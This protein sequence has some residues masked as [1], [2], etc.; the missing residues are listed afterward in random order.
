MGD[1]HKF[2]S[3]GKIIELYPPIQVGQSAKFYFD[4]IKNKSHWSPQLDQ[5]LGTP[6][7]EKSFENIVKLVDV[8]DRA[9]F[10]E[11][12]VGH[13]GEEKIVQTAPIQM[14]NGNVITEKYHFLRTKEN[15]LY[16][17]KGE[18]KLIKVA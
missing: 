7:G 9:K 17:I 8:K 13:T 5:I 10:E 11:M 15:G 18:T 16:G 12:S 14:S 6:D 3:S 4:C 1:K 2:D